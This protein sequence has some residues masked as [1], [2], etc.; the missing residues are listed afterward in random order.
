MCIL[1]NLVGTPRTH[2][3]GVEFPGAAKGV[4]QLSVQ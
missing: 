3:V 2:E 1:P 4:Q